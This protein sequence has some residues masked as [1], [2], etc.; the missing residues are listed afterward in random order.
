MAAERCLNEEV[1]HIFIK[2]AGQWFLVFWVSFIW[3][4]CWINKKGKSYL[5]FIKLNL[6]L[7]SLLEIEIGHREV[8]VHLTKKWSFKP[9]TESF[10][11]GHSFEEKQAHK[12]ALW[13]KFF[14][15]G[16]QGLRR[17]HVNASHL[18][19]ASWLVC[20][21]FTENEIASTKVSCSRK[22]HQP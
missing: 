10:G 3:D 17:P 5:F 22:L 12:T 2:M 21:Y 9:E 19:N 11:L 4:C 8:L 20:K 18:W 13:R 7:S 14:Y 6:F 15:S 16:L 1:I